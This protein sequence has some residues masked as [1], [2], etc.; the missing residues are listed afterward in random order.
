[1][2]AIENKRVFNE[3]KRVFNRR[4]SAS[5]SK[6]E[7]PHVCIV[8]E[9]ESNVGKLIEAYL[10]QEGFAIHVLPIGDDVIQRVEQLHPGL[11]IIE[12]TMA[13]G[14]A[15]GLCLG[16]RRAGIPVIFLSA[17][18][19]EEERILGLEVGADDYV[20]E[21]SSGREIV[22]RVRAVIRRVARQD[23]AAWMR[24]ILPPFCDT[25]A[26]TLN[27][28]LQT[29]DIQIDP[30]AMRIVVRG[31]EVEATNLEFRLLYYL[32]NNQAR[33][34]SRDQLLDAVWGAQNNV[35]LRSVDACVRRL[36]L[37]IEPDPQRPT[38][39]KTVRGA[40]YLLKVA[41]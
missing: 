20:T 8:T 26:G 23:V 11:V 14:T 2:L 33:V 9:R 4:W 5:Q 31:S 19:S 7:T 27:P 16:I 30:S 17:N 36:R 28:T 34:F 29:G 21:V 12:T 13:R 10:A 24:D 38:Y 22:A 6:T 40:G 3:N 32:V 15:L 35:E 18:A 1:M 37:K 41:V 25:A 39:L